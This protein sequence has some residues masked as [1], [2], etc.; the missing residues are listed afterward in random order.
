MIMMIMKLIRLTA[1]GRGRGY[2][3]NDNDDLFYCYHSQYHGYCFVMIVM[4]NGNRNAFNDDNDD[5]LN[6]QHYCYY[7]PYCS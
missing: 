2:I 7:Y 1:G 6:H 5:N 3:N 4:N